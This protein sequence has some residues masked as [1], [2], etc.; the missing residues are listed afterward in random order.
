MSV[1]KLPE[2]GEGVTEGELV[3]WLVK[4]GDVVKPDQ[5]VAEFMTDKATVEVPS[6]IAGRVKVLKFKE[7][8]TVKVES[9]LI[10]LEAGVA[11]T[12]L[13]AVQEAGK[14]REPTDRKS[15]V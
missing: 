1:I 3:K 8:D 12:T 5:P 9:V 10:E 6:P 14:K 4:E 7:G 13:A 2:L 15:V 11:A